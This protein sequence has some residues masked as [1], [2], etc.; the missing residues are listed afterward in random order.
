MDYAE[1]ESIG[2]RQKPITGDW[3]MACAC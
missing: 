1:S 3:G 2:G